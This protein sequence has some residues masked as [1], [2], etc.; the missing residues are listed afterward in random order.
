MPKRLRRK[1]SRQRTAPTSARPGVDS[2]G[3]EATRQR[4]AH[5]L[6]GGAGWTRSSSAGMPFF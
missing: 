2:D 1:S 4:V 3:A 5:T 6:C